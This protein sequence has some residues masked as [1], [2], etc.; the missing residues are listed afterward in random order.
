LR[1]TN[2]YRPK[3]NQ[4][5]RRRS[6]AATTFNSGAQRNVYAPALLMNWVIS[7]GRLM[8]PITKSHFS[9]RA[10]KHFPP[11]RPSV[12]LYWKENYGA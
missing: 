10:V 9:S 8:E 1:A 4:H 11:A 12:R 7:W 5:Q 3:R 2:L 6:K